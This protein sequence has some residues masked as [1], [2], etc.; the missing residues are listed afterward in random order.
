MIFDEIRRLSSVVVSFRSC[1]GA[2]PFEM[3]A[4][5]KA[6]SALEYHLLHLR[7][8]GHQLHY[9]YQS[10]YIAALIYINYVLQ[11]FDPVFGVL[12]KLESNLMNVIEVW[13]NE[14]QATYGRS[15]CHLLLWTLFMG[16]LI[17][18][19]GYKRLWFVVRIARQ[20]ER[21]KLDT[22]KDVEECL[23]KVLWV[24]NINEASQLLW[25]EAI[26]VPK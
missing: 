1:R 22:W 23:M 10:C 26:A 5:S 14:G 12:R 21:L 16:G 13:E 7:A 20:M 6:R 19:N 24:T 8:Y 11:E 17:S 18:G 25:S 2:S 3:L 9:V 15:E 4:F